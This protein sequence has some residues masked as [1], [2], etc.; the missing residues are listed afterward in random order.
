MIGEQIKKLRTARNMSQVGLARMIGVTKQSVSN[1]ENNNILP[2]IDMLIKIADFFSCT[3]DYL[4]EI[5]NTRKVI[6]VNDLTLEQIAH[7]QMIVNDYKQLNA[8]LKAM[9]DDCAYT[10]PD[11]NNN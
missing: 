11:N 2:S 6:E 1:W 5:D 10:N 7:I 8:Q 4:L 9:P 3:T